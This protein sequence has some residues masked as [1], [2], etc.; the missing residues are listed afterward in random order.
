VGLKTHC[1]TTLVIRQEGDLLR[2][3]CHIGTGNYNPATATVYTV[4]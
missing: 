3:Y 1:K 4:R 2:P